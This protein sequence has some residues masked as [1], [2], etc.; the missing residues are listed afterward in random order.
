MGDQD[1]EAAGGA[2]PSGSKFRPASE[3]PCV[4]CN[5]SARNAARLSSQAAQLLQCWLGVSDVAKNESRGSTAQY[6]SPTPYY[7]AWQPP[8]ME[9]PSMPSRF[10]PAIALRTDISAS[11]NRP[12][13]APTNCRAQC[14]FAADALPHV[15]R[16][17]C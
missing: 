14:A 6:S 8:G 10:V 16:D 17:R 12:T 4:Y 5:V 2:A 1:R 3:Y 7:A 13:G 15:C 11:P 9:L